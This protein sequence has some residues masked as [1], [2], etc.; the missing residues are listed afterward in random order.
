MR[1]WQ[2]DEWRV[3][4]QQTSKFQEFLVNQ[5]NR[6]QMDEA[7]SKLLGKLVKRR[8]YGFTHIISDVKS[9]QVP[10]DKSKVGSL[11]PTIPKTSQR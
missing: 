4:F 11:I 5:Y 6:L 9:T 3:R 8:N 1:A 2:S 10:R 7:R